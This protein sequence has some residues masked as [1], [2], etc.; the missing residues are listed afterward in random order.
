[1]NQAANQ[2]QNVSE[3]TI[4]ASQPDVSEETILA[5]Q[6]AAQ[7]GP[8]AAADSTVLA[9]A[10]SHADATALASSASATASHMPHVQMPDLPPRT[11]GTTDMSNA[12]ASAASSISPTSPQ[13]TPLST[14]Q[15]H[16]QPAA[17]PTH[18]MPAMPAKPTPSTQPATSTQPAA[19]SPQ[20]AATSPQPAT[21]TTNTT[22]AVLPPLGVQA[23]ASTASKEDIARFAQDFQKIQEN[24]SQ[25]V[26][27]K[28]VPVRQCITALIAGGHI[29][30]EDNPGT[31]KTQLARGMAHSLADDNADEAFKRIQ[32]TPDLL[33][34]DVVG[35]T[36]YD[37]KTG[38]F[39]FRKGP[40]F[41]SV[42]L[43]DEINRA[44]PKTQSALLEVME[45]QKV[46]VDGVT[47]AVPQ[48]FIV[49]AT[50]N[51]VE[52]L[53]TYKLPEAQMDRFLIKTTIGYPA[54]EFSIDLLK[55]VNI[56]DRASSVSPVISR[57]EILEMRQIAEQVF[58][59]DVLLEYIVRLV[60]ATRHHADVAVGSSM[61][62]AL[63]LTRC[64]RVWAAS[65]GRG[66]V[67]PDD[68]N[69]LAVPVLAHRMVLT[70]EA[71]FTAVTPENI[72]E[73]IVEEVPAPQMG[74]SA[75]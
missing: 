12:T 16:A 58:I 49:I 74:A 25:V 39:T 68:I 46:T 38:D 23:G 32:F 33:P 7:P 5:D 3:E 37:Q 71:L 27:G 22:L 28:D 4:L 59:D 72:I 24:V 41:A 69:A 54:H 51:P 53:G 62:G 36:F 18:P 29:L 45:E 44:S 50:Q 11:H 60:E 66:Y 13:P 21:S 56:R 2:P 20:P 8:A 47:Y 1:M 26:V 48:P 35:V 34:S 75:V 61:R 40:V 31:G 63:A 43:A 64:A 30:L 55:Q 10:T 15:T 9:D 52:Q 70:S 57:K 17:Q 19:T 6:T 73:R 42:V 65:Q 67:V 14:P